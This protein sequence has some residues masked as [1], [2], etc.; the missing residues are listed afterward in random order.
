MTRL[1]R[2]LP[3]HHVLAARRMRFGGQHTPH[4]SKRHGE[5]DA[6]VHDHASLML[7]LGGRATL[8]AG[9]SY[10]I[11][12]GTVCLIPEGQAHYMNLEEEGLDLLGLALCPHCTR[13]PWSEP[14]LGLFE[15]V[16]LGQSAAYRVARPEME[17]MAET[18][19]RL[20][21]Q[22]ESS[23]PHGHEQLLEDGLM[24]V[25]TAQLCVAIARSVPLETPPSVTSLTSRAL[26]YIQQHAT[27]SISLID[28]ANAVGR[29]PSHVATCVKEESGRTVGEWITH[30]RMAYA[31]Q[32]LRASQDNIEHIAEQVGFASASH[33]HRTFKTWHGVSPGTWRR[34]HEQG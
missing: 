32:L 31:R 5:L 18:L 7:C 33:F 4:H 2:T 17:A 19:E 12:E 22:L 3:R 11:E 25:F 30:T 26:L 9:A 29:H 8:W 21:R 14:L 20:A 6:V 1:I 13:P 10:T 27:Q 34:E 15:N 28:V 16:L 23:E 24:C